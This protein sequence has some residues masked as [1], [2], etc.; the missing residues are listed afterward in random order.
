MGMHELPQGERFL[1]EGQCRLLQHVVPRAQIGGD[2][3]GR[4]SQSAPEQP[5]L[6]IA[7]TDSHCSRPATFSFFFC[8]LL[9]AATRFR[10][11]NCC[12]LPEPS[13]SS[14]SSSPSSGASDGSF[15]FSLRVDAAVDFLREA[16][17]FDPEGVAAGAGET[18]VLLLALPSARDE[19]VPRLLCPRVTG[20]RGAWDSARLV[21]A[22]RS[23]CSSPGSALT[24]MSAA[25]DSGAIGARAGTA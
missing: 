6:T 24:E 20:G 19:R 16:L 4:K 10:S 22:A 14:S 5:R 7:L 8:R 23:C 3:N 13:P 21:E 11:K 25:A 17:R 9:H 12:R 1:A 18:P 2:C 15:V